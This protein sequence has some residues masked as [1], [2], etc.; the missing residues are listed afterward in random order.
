MMPA[1]IVSIAIAMSTYAGTQ[2]FH[3]ANQVF[4]A[5]CLEIV[6][7]DALQGLSDLRLYACRVLLY[8]KKA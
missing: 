2:A 3:F 6:V 8:T 7:H 1:E 4:T 5:K